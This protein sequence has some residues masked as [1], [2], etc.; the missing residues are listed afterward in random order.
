MQL[1]IIRLE[2]SVILSLLS[3]VRLK[4][5]CKQGINYCNSSQ[6]KEE[7]CHTLNRDTWRLTIS[8]MLIVPFPWDNGGGL[9]RPSMEARLAE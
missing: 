6:T 2:K 9:I 7:K 4:I 8:S 3:S 5:G 1:K